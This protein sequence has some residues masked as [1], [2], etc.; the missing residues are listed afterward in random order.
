MLCACSSHSQHQTELNGDGAVVL[1][2]IQLQFIIIKRWSCQQLLLAVTAL[3]QS[4]TTI[5]I[6]VTHFG[7]TV[8]HFEWD[9]FRVMPRLQIPGYPSHKSNHCALRPVCCS[10]E[11]GEL[12]NQA[13]LLLL[14]AS[15]HDAAAKHASDALEITQK[16]FGPTHPLTGHRL[17]RLG[18]IR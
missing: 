4:S 8:A 2:A 16:R 18:T 14:F 5:S 15:Q 1:F 17:L 6:T 7:F 3:N 9:S 13:A 12:H 11:L 10:P